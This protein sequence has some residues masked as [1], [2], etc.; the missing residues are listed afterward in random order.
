MNIV[1][2]LSSS[3]PDDLRYRLS[4]AYAVHNLEQQTQVQLQFNH[5]LFIWKLINWFFYVIG[6]ILHAYLRR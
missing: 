6:E 3:H 1:E 5:I 2:Y 4:I